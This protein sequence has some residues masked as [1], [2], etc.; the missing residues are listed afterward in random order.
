MRKS[1]VK[2]KVTGA[3][4]KVSGVRGPAA[5]RRM[6][7]AMRE[8]RA[9]RLA[10]GLCIACGLEPTRPGKTKGAACAAKNAAYY[11]RKLGRPERKA[12]VGFAALVAEFGSAPEASKITKFPNH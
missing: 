11:R 3:V 8:L 4:K 6:A 5:E 9:R 7:E 2:V 12:T 1:K 10:Q